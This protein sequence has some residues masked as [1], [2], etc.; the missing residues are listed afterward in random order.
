M[1]KDI[2]DVEIIDAYQE[3]MSEEGFRAKLKEIHP[4][5]VGIT[6][7]MDEYGRSGH[8]CAEL[9]KGADCNIKTVIG[10]VY[11]TVNSTQV[12]QDRNIDFAVVGEGEYTFRELIGYLL[13]RN[14]MPQNGVCYREGVAVVDT[15]H[16][17]FIR[18]LDALPSPAYDLI[19]FNKYSNS[20]S[21]KS[22]DAPRAYP[23]ARIIT[24]RGCPF[25]CVFCQVAH[26]SGKSFRARSADNVLD[27]IQLLKDKYGIKS[28]IF[29]DDNLLFDKQRAMDIFKGMID[30]GL[31]MPW[32]MIA[33]AVY[34]LDTALLQVMKVSGCEYIDVAFETGTERVMKQVIDKPV[35]LA[36]AKK[37]VSYARY[38][39]IFVTANFIIGFP[40]ETWAEIRSTLKFAEDLN[41]DYVKIFSPIPLRNTRLWDI[42][43]QEGYFK[44]DFDGGRI[45]WS[46][47]Q[48]ETKEFSADALTILRA[49]E[50]DRINFSDPV[51]LANICLIMGVTLDEMNTIRKRTLDNAIQLIRNGAIDELPCSIRT[52]TMECHS[53]RG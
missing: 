44:K 33:T 35:D 53:G 23:Y 50:W 30:R 26:I 13:G 29:D 46:T 41:A 3:N 16:S 6:V 12:M 37:M 7:L 22:V 8:I 14:S 27:E 21:R 11:A 20:A 15:G 49:F 51:K 52:P 18:N 1:V 5:V 19:D 9:A 42:C 43:E 45:K 10:G 47:G 28:I 40:T 24:S 17:E 2:C 39:G 4:D 34:K 36:Y 31:V 25:N 32:V 48:I 38:L